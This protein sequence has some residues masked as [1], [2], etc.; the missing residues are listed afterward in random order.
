MKIFGWFC[1]ILGAFSFIGAAIYGHSVFGP[2][3]WL[4]LGIYLL[5]RAKKNKEEK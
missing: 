4:A 1:T 5:Y 2:A 3:F